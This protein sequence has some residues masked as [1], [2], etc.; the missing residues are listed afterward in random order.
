MPPCILIVDDDCEFLDLMKECLTSRGFEV[1][2]APDSEAFRESAFSRRPD[3]II[4][5][6]MLGESNGVHAYEN[7]ILD[8][9]DAKVPVIFLS[10][11]AKDRPPSPASEGRR[12]ALHSK[13]IQVDYLVGEINRLI[14]S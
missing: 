6:I 10:G 13:P 11:L 12:Y 8:G 9:F 5:D 14:H 2:L 1:A 4:L 3:L 7:L